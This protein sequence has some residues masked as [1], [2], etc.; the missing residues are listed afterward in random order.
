ME[1]TIPSGWHEVTLQQLRILAEHSLL[2]MPREAS[3][4][5]LLCKL[6]GLTMLPSPGRDGETLNGMMKFRDAGGREFALEGW[7]LASFCKRL[8]WFYDDM[9]CDI[10]CPVEVNP[11]LL[12]TS[13]GDYFHAD[14]LMCG[15]ADTGDIN[16]M[17]EAMSDLGVGR[18]E[19]TEVEAV[20]VQLWWRGFKQWLC[21]EYPLVFAG[22][23][24]DGDGSYS[25]LKA[26][27]N[28]MLILN[29]GHPQDND[30]IEKANMHDVLSALQHH[31]EI[32]KKEEEVMRRHKR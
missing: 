19:I 18:K 21:D 12:A 5:S 4:V 24:D 29:D 15:F 11:R 23:R 31:I 8:A 27:Q 1:L 14:A 25:P 2:E 26:R 17:L 16:V 13:F 10:A 20:M 6:A 7:Q 32:A 3:E 22:S 30:A 9:P 28:I